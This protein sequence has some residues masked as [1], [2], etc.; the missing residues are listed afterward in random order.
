LSENKLEVLPQTT[1]SF[2][3][4]KNDAEIADEFYSSSDEELSLKRK[5]LIEENSLPQGEIGSSATFLL[6]ARLDLVELFASTIVSC[7]D[8]G[9]K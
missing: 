6:G 4:K 9:K 3:T 2:R 8:Q 5:M 7:P 1:S